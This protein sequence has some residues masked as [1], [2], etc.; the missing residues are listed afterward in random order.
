MA[1][2]PTKTKIIKQLKH[3]SPLISCRFDPTGKYVFFGAQDNRIWRWDPTA[4][5]KKDFVG[6]DSWIRS[7]VFSNDG[8]TLITGGY[9]G[10]LIW[11]EAN[12]EEPKPIRTVD[13]HKG[14]IRA[15]AVS[16]DGQLVAT[17]GDDLFLRLWN[18]SD[19]SLVREITGKHER[20]IYNVAFHPDGKQIVTGD[21]MGKL[22]HWNV[23]TGEFV[24][25]MTVEALSKYDKG[26]R[27]QIGGFRALE[28]NTDGTVLAC[29]GITDVT[30]AFAGVGQPLI[31]LWDWKEAKQLSQHRS[32]GKSEGV[33]WGVAVH[34]ENFTIG[35]LGGRAGGIMFFWKPDSKDEFHQFKLPDS[36][37]DLDL[38]PDGVQLVTAHY[39]KH[40]RISSMDPPEEPKP[41]EAKE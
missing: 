17:V 21:L 26:F 9:D 8:M 41:E 7:I 29:A 22:N 33:A 18:L 2:D 1:I 24:R 34:P 37:R 28:F 13:A 38:H 23:E 19:G 39:D 20:Y 4:D 30:N 6:H 32:K 31:E 14:W 40:V 35:I 11:W 27:A 15:A 16:P 36:A 5:S 12:A 3:E 25:D 10:R